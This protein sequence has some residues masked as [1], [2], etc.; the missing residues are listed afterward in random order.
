[1]RRSATRPR[2]VPAFRPALLWPILLSGMLLFAAGCGRSAPTRFY[3]L[4][5]G[6]GEAPAPI[7]G[8]V[9][10]GVGPVD[11]PDY[12]DRPHLLTRAGAHEIRFAEFDQWAG[13]LK[14]NI[15]SVVAENLGRRL[16]LDAVHV[17]PWPAAVRPAAQVAV[18]VVRLDA[19]PGEDAVLEARWTILEEDGRR[20]RFTRKSAFRVPVADADY[21]GIVDA[22]SRLFEALSREVAEAIRNLPIR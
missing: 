11:L 12:L 9:A 8:S 16:G 17:Y 15:A 10:V 3:L 18:S 13:S 14:H 19:V 7:D 21:A 1:M 4:T 22:W 20:V 6:A 2:F 5:P